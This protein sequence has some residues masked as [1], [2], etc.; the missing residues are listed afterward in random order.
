MENM[1]NES[2]AKLGPQQ[3]DASTQV[4]TNLPKPAVSSPPIPTAG[5]NNGFDLNLPT[6]ESGGGAIDP[7]S[8]AIG[9]GLASAAAAAAKRRKS[10]CKAIHAEGTDASG[11]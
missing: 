2:L 1:R 10:Q 5:P 3:A 8:A 9:L 11:A 6:G 4:A 7:L